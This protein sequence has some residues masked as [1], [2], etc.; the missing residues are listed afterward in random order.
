MDKHFQLVSRL[1]IAI[2]SVLLI[3]LTIHKAQVSSFTHDESFTFN[4]SVTESVG[5][6]FNYKVISPNNHLLNTL[7][8]KVCAALFGT[9]SLSLRLP[10][11]FAHVFFL[12]FSWLLIRRQDP[13]IILPL[14]ILLNFNPYL[15]DFFALAR[16]NGLSYC[17]LL[18]SIYYFIRYL[19]QERTGLYLVSAFLGLLGVLSHLTMLYFLLSLVIVSNLRP[20]LN[21]YF[22]PAYRQSG[23]RQFIRINVINLLIILIFLVIMVKPMIRLIEADQLFYGGD[24][25]FWKDTVGS[26][27]E[28]FLYAMPYGIFWSP[29]LKALV[30]ITL[31]A[32]FLLIIIIFLKRSSRLFIENQ[33]LIII[34]FLLSFT[35]IINV[36]QFNLIGTKLLIRRYGLLYA[37]LFMLCLGYL[38]SFLARTGKLKRMWIFVSYGMALL[39]SCH[40]L[41][42]FPATTYL[43]WDYEKQTKHVMTLLENDVCRDRPA[44]PVTLGITW[45]FEPTVNFYRQTHGLT[46]LTEVNRDGPVIR[47]DYYYV[48]HDERDRVPLHGNLPRILFDDGLTMLIKVPGGPGSR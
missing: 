12:L 25:G 21:K 34:F 29:I 31:S 20:F 2:L 5:D 23:L 32:A 39:I 42:S 4:H 27:I 1:L 18:G 37:P 30:L 48:I 43:D 16:G 38:I 8:M 46:W 10:N 6:I 33:D 9:T 36:S 40:T 47:A 13:R 41:Y 45:I 19:D 7:L 44:H 26:L 28:T 17:F 11:I 35:V 3:T 14:F 22:I 15:L 24:L